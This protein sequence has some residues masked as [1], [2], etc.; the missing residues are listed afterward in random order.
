MP[1]NN[2]FDL[3]IEDFKITAQE[4]KDS[5]AD[6]YTDF[7]PTEDNPVM[8]FYYNDESSVTFS[9]KYISILE[10]ISTYEG[11]PHGNLAYKSTCYDT[12]K[13]EFVDVCAVTGKT[14]EEIVSYCKDEIRK[15]VYADSDEDEIQMW[16]GSDIAIDNFYTKDGI[17]TICFAPY[18]V[19]S[20]A[21]GPV[22]VE[23]K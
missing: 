9:G 3:K 22:W 23:L 16:L 10:T 17:T 6:F 19:A 14:L 8:S 4:Y 2:Y 20:Y 21:V 15:T 18:D 5:W 7:L 12:E 1:L 13:K 11:G